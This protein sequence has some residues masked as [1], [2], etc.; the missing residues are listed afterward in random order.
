MNDETKNK[1]AIAL[2]GIGGVLGVLALVLSSNKKGSGISVSFTASTFGALDYAFV[3]RVSGGT[4]PYTYDW[5]F[6]D[7][8]TSIERAPIHTYDKAGTYTIELM[9]VDSA[10]EQKTVTQILTAKAGGGTIPSGG[11]ID[12]ST[13]ITAEDIAIIKASIAKGEKIYSAGFLGWAEKA[14]VDGCSVGD[15]QMAAAY[16]VSISDLPALKAQLLAANQG[17][18]RNAAAQTEGLG[19]LTIAGEEQ[20]SIWI[21]EGD[22]LSIYEQMVSFGAKGNKWYKSYW[23]S[24][25]PPL[26]FAEW[27][28]E[29]GYSLPLNSVEKTKEWI[30]YFEASARRELVPN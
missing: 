22:Y 30:E 1:L 8:S 11:V 16:G 15:E 28:R 3:P 25:P 27:A 10:G 18:A 9:V 17:I 12:T 23:V 21:D 5:S 26:T 19:E 24:Y 13:V 4:A 7:G 2:L 14:L 20:L 6:G 29:K